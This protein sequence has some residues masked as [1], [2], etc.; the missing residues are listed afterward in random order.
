MI[1][2]SHPPRRRWLAKSASL[3]LGLFAGRALALTG[4]PSVATNERH[5]SI[6]DLNK[7]LYNALKGHIWYPSDAIQLDVPLLA[8]NGAIVPITIQSHLP[9]TRR[10][11]IFAEN[12]P[13]PQLAEFHFDP[14]VS[15]WASLRV[16]LNESGPVLV[17][18]ES[19]GNFYGIQKPV[20]VM[21]GGCG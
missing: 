2:E 5:P 14:G 15:P 4:K 10:L 18:A 17:I 3:V 16:K 6:S 8:E 9:A 19:E 13:R 1:R 21:V 12:N 7:V 20:K 11:L